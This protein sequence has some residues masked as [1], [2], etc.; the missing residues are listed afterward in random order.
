MATVILPLI[1]QPGCWSWATRDNDDCT[2]TPIT[3]AGMPTCQ[4]TGVDEYDAPCEGAPT[5]TVTDPQG[6]E[7]ILCT[8]CAEAARAMEP[9]A[10]PWC[11]DA[12]WDGNSKPDH[13]RNLQAWDR[14]IEEH[15]TECEPAQ[16]EMGVDL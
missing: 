5:V 9:W 7:H 14:W 3:F 4:A 16:R 12:T 13:S 1:H 2:C 11:G 10:C 15:A 6:H 8:D